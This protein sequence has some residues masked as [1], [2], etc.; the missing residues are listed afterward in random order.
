MSAL[1]PAVE[2]PRGP[3][4][5]AGTS[6]SELGVRS[7]LVR[8][9]GTR[10]ELFGL[11]LRANLLMLPTLGLY[12]FWMVT[13]KRR[14]YWSNTEIGGDTLE[15]TGHAIQ[16]LIGFLFALGFFLPIYIAFFYLSTQT[17]ELATLGYGTV[18][19]VLWFLS[20]YAYYRGRDFRLSRT[21]WRGIRFDQ[22][23]GAWAYALRRFGWSI[24]MVLTLGLI[25]PFMA[26]NLWRYRYNH[27][28]YGD[29]KFTM[30]GS[31]RNLAGPFYRAYFLVSAGVI[32]VFWYIAANDAVVLYEGRTIPDV[33]ASALGVLVVVLGILAHFYY[34]AKE[35]S[36]MLSSVRLGTASLTVRVR[37]RSLFGQFIVYALLVGVAVAV[38]GGIAAVII[39]GISPSQGTGTEVGRV[40]QAGWPVLLLLIFVYLAFLATFG[41]IGEVILAFGFWKL[42]ARE[43]TVADLE[44]LASVRAAAEDR[45]LVGEGLA[46]AL[47]AGAY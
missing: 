12:R 36:R 19:L 35:T 41:L 29:R 3:W 9:T 39:S 28:W 44:S 11:L 43:A 30:E 34:R 24:L 23:G 37:A 7:A 14:F 18:G 8:F 38:F 45:S 47:N 15:Y 40:L 13:W 2:L 22:K 5:A 17:S 16:L 42:V 31:W 21:L 20:G 6:A 25:Y 32:G 10:R 26:G 27:T 46:D 4:Q 33:N 1:D